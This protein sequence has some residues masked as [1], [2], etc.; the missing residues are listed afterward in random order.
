MQ[1]IFLFLS[2]LISTLGFTQNNSYELV[3]DVQE[4]KNG[5]NLSYKM[6]WKIDG[7][8]AVLEIDYIGSGTSNLVLLS[9]NN[10]LYV[11]SKKQTT[12]G[13]NHYYKSLGNHDNVKYTIMATQNKTQ[14]N[15]YNAQE[16]IMRSATK[17]V[18]FWFTEDIDITFSS[19]AKILESVDFKGLS[20]VVPSQGAILEYT[21]KEN[22][23][24][25]SK[26]NFKSFGSASFNPLVFD[27]PTGYTLFTK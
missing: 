9:K 27:F 18:S 17:E 13:I 12:S 21:I 19:F 16:F 4:F 1:K 24:L 26:V 7:T 6:I 8:Q 2:L 3:Q 22:G 10:E 15:G 23:T 14:I 20:G 25:I 5:E 11:Y